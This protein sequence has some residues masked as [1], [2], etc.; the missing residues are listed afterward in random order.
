MLFELSLLNI[1]SEMYSNVVYSDWSE[2][3]RHYAVP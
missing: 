1:K 2:T 3:E